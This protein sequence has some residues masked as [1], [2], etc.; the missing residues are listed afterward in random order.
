M[1]VNNPV[2]IF[3]QSYFIF[4]EYAVHIFFISMIE[5]EEQLKKRVYWII[6]YHY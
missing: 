3:Q 6:P 5:K 4:H 1:I 2:I